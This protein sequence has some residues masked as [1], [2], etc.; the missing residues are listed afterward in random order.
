M[1]INGALKDMSVADLIQSYC[2][3]KKTAHV[4]IQSNGSQAEIYIQ[5]GQVVH[6]V[7]DEYWGDEAVY[8]VLAWEEGEFSLE[9]GVDAPEITIER[10]WPGLL[11]EGAKR[12]D[13]TNLTNSDELITELYKETEPMATRKKGEILADEIKGFLDESTD[14]YGAAVVG[15][16]GLVY[17]ANVPQKGIDET[18][19]GGAAASIFGLSKRGVEQLHKG[20]YTRTLI[21]GDD[22]DIIIQPINSETLLIALTPANANLGMAFAEVRSATNKLRA[23]L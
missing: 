20:T 23:I 3:D 18:I 13:E 10:N 12:L 2:Q 21:T 7:S 22:G 9:T 16:D 5:D 1:A 8:E 17:S 11:L 15:F 19:V 4:S 6:A 14:I